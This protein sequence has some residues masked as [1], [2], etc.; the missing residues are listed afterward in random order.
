MDISFFGATDIGRLRT[1][2]EDSF[3]AAKIWG[4]KYL[5][6]VAIDGMGGE[7]GGEVAADIA[8]R[9]IREYLSRICD[10]TPLNLIKMAV[11]EANNKIIEEKQRQPQYQR[12]GCVL[13]AGIVDIENRTLSIAHV[14]DSRLY[15]FAGGNLSKLTHDHSLVGYQEEQGILTE[16]QA[17]RHPRRSVIERCLGAEMHN[18]EDKNFIEAGI[19]PLNDGEILLFC[20]DGLSDVLTSAQIADSLRQNNQPQQICADLIDKANAA[21]GKDNITVVTAVIGSPLT[22]PSLIKPT[23]VIRNEEIIPTSQPACPPK[24]KY[25]IILITAIIL[26]AAAGF[27]TARYIYHKESPQ[28]PPITVKQPSPSPPAV[29]LDTAAHNDTI[30]HTPPQQLK[31]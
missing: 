29:P 17:M 4:D 7:E 2:N 23:P 9:T 1:N 22:K 3:I 6:L 30:T 14:G 27:F 13:T 10:D 11:V 15:R 16:E 21:G 26:S 28:Q 20:S 18:P 25:I 19:F 31:Q 5:L 24:H 12:M 8:N